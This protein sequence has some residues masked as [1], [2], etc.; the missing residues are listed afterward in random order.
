MKYKKLVIVVILFMLL[1]SLIMNAAIL[2][3]FGTLLE[4]NSALNLQI[5]QLRTAALESVGADDEKLR[6]LAEKIDSLSRQIETLSFDSLPQEE[7][8]PLAEL[9][10]DDDTPL[11]GS[12]KGG[13]NLTSTVKKPVSTDSHVE[14]SVSPE[15]V[16]ALAPPMQPSPSPS[17]SA[18]PQIKA[19]QQIVVKVTAA[20]IADLYGY[21]FELSFD[22]TLFSYSGSVQSGIAEI[23]TIFGKKL[24][25][26]LLIGA[27]MTGDRQ[28]VSGGET[29]VCVVT[30]T[31]LK[32]CEIPEATI[33]AVCVVQGNMEYIEN[34]GGWSCIVNP[35]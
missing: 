13:V 19:G 22:M 30:L 2:G 21:Q 26:H 17:P 5:E 4:N 3:K 9:S 11:S 33:K 14:V 15:P 20:E 24:E 8:V 31:A 32:D 27:T 25:D 35:I 18:Q 10:G 28:G 12:E 23:S 34:I 1:A 16:L 6:S 29:E 7:P